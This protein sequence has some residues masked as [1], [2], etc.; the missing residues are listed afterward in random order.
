[1]NNVAVA[2]VGPVGQS[3]PQSEL[4]RGLKVNYISVV[5]AIR[6]D[7]ALMTDDRAGSST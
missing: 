4:D 7:A 6:V 5:A 1:M 3:P 2:V